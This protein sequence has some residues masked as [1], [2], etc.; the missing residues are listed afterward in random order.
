[1]A[2]ETV[3]SQAKRAKGASNILR[4]ASTAEKSK[5][6]SFLAETLEANRDKILA[7]NLNDLQAASG[8][9]AA[10]QRRLTLDSKAL[11]GIIKSVR[12]IASAEDPVGKIVKDI[13]GH[14]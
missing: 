4:Q 11:S 7:E 6:L 3:V 13:E 2:Q 8:L 10:M 5:F 9:S 12:D 14:D 1:M